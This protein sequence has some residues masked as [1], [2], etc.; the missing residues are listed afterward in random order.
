MA[1]IQLQLNNKPLT[2]HYANLALDYD[3]NN[4]NAL[5]VLAVLY[6]KSGETVLADK[7]I[8]TLST[9]DPLSHFADFERYLL[10]N[11]SENLTR[12]TS[13]I[14]N[15]LPYQTYLELC[16]IYYG[17]GLK[18][19]ALAVLDKSP[20]HPLITVWKAYLKDD[21]SMLNEVVS[22]S[23]A[24]VFPYRTETVSALTMGP[25]KE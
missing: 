12:F 2:E 25:F 6:R 7:F 14:T 4:I 18:D 1:E 5:Q 17:F 8:Q 21:A 22:A 16:M 10:H 11:S 13:T 9:L 24:Y 3:R 20:S 23:P 15:E 19:D